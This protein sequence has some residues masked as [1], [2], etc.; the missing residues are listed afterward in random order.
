MLSGAIYECR[1]H[2]SRISWFIW[3]YMFSIVHYIA[4]SNIKCP[5]WHIQSSRNTQWLW[6]RMHHWKTWKTKLGTDCHGE[7]LSKCLLRA[8]KNLTA[9]TVISYDLVTATHILT[10]GKWVHMYFI[11]L[12]RSRTLKLWNIQSFKALLCCVW[13]QFSYMLRK[14]TLDVNSW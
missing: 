13:P 5:C 10:L 7:N 3:Y 12:W 4:C 8:N 2:L 9:Y 6:W 11:W 14:R 1:I